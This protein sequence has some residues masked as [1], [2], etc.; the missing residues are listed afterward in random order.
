MAGL[1]AIAPR[2]L[3]IVARVMLYA[4][5]VRA[6]YWSTLA[7]LYA[8]RD[9]AGSWISIVQADLTWFAASSDKLEELRGASLSERST[10]LASK[11]ATLG[12][13]LQEVAVAETLKVVHQATAAVSDP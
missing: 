5:V 2:F 9:S 7:A 12:R 3:F 6:P 11:R 10:L 8:N 4:R 1:G 13:L